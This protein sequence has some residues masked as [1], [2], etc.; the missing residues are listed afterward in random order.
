MPQ[1]I[2]TKPVVPKD[3]PRVECIWK[4]FQHDHSYTW[5][6]H[7]GFRESSNCTWITKIDALMTIPAAIE[8]MEALKLD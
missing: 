6:P 1:H 3:S 2:S 8:A 4:K 5:P 7:H